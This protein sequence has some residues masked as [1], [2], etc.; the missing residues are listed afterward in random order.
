MGVWCKAPA[1]HNGLPETIHFGAVGEGDVCVKQAVQGVGFDG[2]LDHGVKL[3]GGGVETVG[4][5]G[6]VGVAP[7]GACYEGY[8]LA[9]CG[10]G[11]GKGG[12]EVV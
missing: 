10:S 5:G 8:A 1:E 6:V 12:T 9:R 11:F 2:L 7:I 4:S 3:G